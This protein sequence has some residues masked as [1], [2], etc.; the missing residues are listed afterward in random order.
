MVMATAKLN[1]ITYL[2]YESY[3]HVFIYEYI[4]KQNINRLCITV[5]IQQEGNAF[6]DKFNKLNKN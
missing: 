1:T 2:V 6:K 5:E 4:T 3:P